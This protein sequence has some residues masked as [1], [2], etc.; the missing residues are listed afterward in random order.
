[1]EDTVTSQILN[2]RFTDR[3]QILAVSCVLI[4][5]EVSRPV[6]AW[7]VSQA[8]DN[9]TPSSLERYAQAMRL[10][11][12]YYARFGSGTPAEALVRKFS[13][14][15]EDGCPEL[16]WKPVS[17]RT[18][19]NYFNALNQFCDWLVLQEGLKQFQHPNPVVEQ[20]MTEPERVIAELRS[21]QS[22]M[23][24]HLF[25]LTKEGKG[26]KEVRKVKRRRNRFKKHHGGLTSL[27]DSTSHAT[28]YSPIGMSLTDYW[29]L[30]E[31]EKSP[32]NLL[33]W[34]LLGAGGCRVSET[35][36]IFGTDIFYQQSAQQALVA[37]ANPVEG[38]VP[39]ARGSFMKRIQ[40]L[41]QK[42][43]LTPRC[44][45]PKSDPLHAGWKGM[46]EGGL[47]DESIPEIAEWADHRW[48]LVEWLLP[49]FGRMFWRA[50][51]AYMEEKRGKVMRHPYYFVNMKRNAGAPLTRSA[52]A[53]LLATACRH[54]GIK[55]R[56]PHRLRHLYGNCLADW[57]IPLTTAQ[58]MMRHVS[59]ASTLVYYQASRSVTRKKLMEAQKLSIKERHDLLAERQL[60]LLPEGT[61]RIPGQSF[62][63]TK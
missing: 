23:L 50:H 60:A 5:G 54:A 45:L 40:Y 2:L 53:Q 18:A 31:L 14:A 51:V 17:G 8:R 21:K 27:N 28:G 41:K 56:R 4:N 46:V 44:L 59:P 57:G 42:Y 47:H 35:L 37:L 58:L 38:D 63:L 7:L 61:L 19:D 25:L 11:A 6:L 39:V 13:D 1:M 33:L 10:F 36:N 48:S 16:G 43:S 52:V 3:G 20:R 26:I 55:E 12:A 15:L 34:L 62:K 22:S 29:R 32:R 49:V 30:L 9:A 24:H